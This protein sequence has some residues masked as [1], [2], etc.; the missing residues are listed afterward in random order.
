MLTRIFII[1]VCLLS[2]WGC[3]PFESREAAVSSSD[4]AHATAIRRV[5]LIGE[6]DWGTVELTGSGKVR[7]RLVLSLDRQGSK[8]NK[9]V[10]LPSCFVPLSPNTQIGRIKCTEG[11]EMEIPLLAKHIFQECYTNNQ[12]P[13]VPPSEDII[14][15][16]CLRAQLQGFHFD[17]TIRM[18]IEL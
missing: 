16:G 6:I 10:T 5:D 1:A 18:D 3:K 7:G 4:G 14:M 8:H 11:Q 17:P 2:E 15:S 9:G 12:L 13:K